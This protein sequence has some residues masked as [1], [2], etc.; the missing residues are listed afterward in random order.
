MLGSYFHYKIL[1]VLVIVRVH[2][3]R[4]SKYIL[5]LSTMLTVAVDEVV[6]TRP[7]PLTAESVTVNDSVVSVLESSIIET[8]IC[9]VASLVSPALNIAR[10]PETLS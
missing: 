3:Q 2:V 5:S 6:G 8:E 9:F 7:P 1:G 10:E 4:K